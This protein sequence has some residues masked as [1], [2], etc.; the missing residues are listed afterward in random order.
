MKV[1]ASSI[2][3]IILSILAVS[4]LA[5]APVASEAASFTPTR[6]IEFVC[7]ASP[8]GGS[9][10]FAETVGSI[11][12]KE[13]IVPVAMPRIFKPGGGFAVGMAY[14]AEKKGN[15]HYL[16]STANPFILTPLA[17]TISGKKTITHR[18]FTQIAIL[19]YDEMAV[20]VKYD[21]PFKSLKD[22][23]AAA[24]AKSKSVKFGGTNVGGTDSL[25]IQS[26]AKAAG[27][28]FNYIA[29]QGGGEVNAALLG[30]HIDAMSSNPTEMLP[31]VEGK[32]MRMLA[33]AS[34]KRLAGD[35]FKDL[36]TMKELGYNVVFNTHRG[37]TAPAGIPAEAVAYYENAF[38]K[39]SENAVFKKYI[40]DN[41]MTPT[42]LNSVQATKYMNDFADQAAGLL[43][44]LGI[45]KK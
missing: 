13:K 33:V 38:K 24:K 20:V 37:I 3:I 19:A 8:G 18:D 7:F 23:I 45:V 36:P 34:E 42:Y 27:V 22:L 6:P 14:L 28:E 1:S 40:A 12:E 21:S 43:K 39:L 30:G 17:V 26:L 41:D 29:F 10:I 15:P 9:G 44:D 16:G 11:M 5:M 32:T 31:Q 35:K 2:R 4:V 25:L